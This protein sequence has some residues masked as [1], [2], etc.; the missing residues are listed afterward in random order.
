MPVIPM[1]PVLFTET[2]PVP[3]CE[4]PVI[5]NADPFVREITPVPLFAALKLV[6]VLAFPKVV[7]VAELVVSNAPLIKPAPASFTVPA[8]AVKKTLPVVLIPPAFKVTFVPP[9]KLI[10]PEPLVTLEFRLML[11]VPAFSLKVIAL[12]PVVET[13]VAVPKSSVRL[14]TVKFLL[15]ASNIDIGPVTLFVAILLNVFA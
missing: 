5:V 12:L 7:P 6:T 10:T 14:V 11:P 13:P 9:V 1:L 2:A 3:V 4:I 15:A 8:E